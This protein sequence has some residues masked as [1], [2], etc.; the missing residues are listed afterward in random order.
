MDELSRSTP[1]MDEKGHLNPHDSQ[2]CP[3][4]D[5]GYMVIGGNLITSITQEQT[6]Q[7]LRI[8]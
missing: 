3:V 6:R 5:S 2:L 8:T 4:I 1:C 7:G